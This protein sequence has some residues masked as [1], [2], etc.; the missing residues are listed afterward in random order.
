MSLSGFDGTFDIAICDVKTRPWWPAN[1][2]VRIHRARCRD[3]C[4]CPQKSESRYF[5]LVP[6]PCFWRGEGGPARRPVDEGGCRTRPIGSPLTRSVSR[7]TALSPLVRGEGGKQS[8]QSEGLDLK[9]KQRKT[10]NG[11][12][13]AARQTNRGGVALGPFYRSLGEESDLACEPARHS[14]QR[15]SSEAGSG[16]WETFRNCWAG[17]C[18]SALGFRASNESL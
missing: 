1:P 13:A 2:A 12:T 11:S 15:R 9:T 14:A 10:N 5:Y 18:I 7:R 3:G 17:S 8:R 16:R 4:L 6:S